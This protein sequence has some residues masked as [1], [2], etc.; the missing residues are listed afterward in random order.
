M[1]EF[2]ID[3]KIN[4]SKEKVWKAVTDFENYPRWNSV[5]IME[6]NNDLTLGEKFH[7][8]IISVKG[9]K[10]KFKAV[11]INKVENHSFSA[12]R[13]MRIGKWFFQAI[14][15]FI[16]KEI[17]DNNVIFSQEWELKGLVAS[18][19]RKKIHAELAVFT[20]MNEELK[21]LIEN[22]E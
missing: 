14:H 16:T 19:M 5:L 13:T 9:I 22:N 18:L 15:H 1:N 2:K 12:K 11:A 8:T 7:V 10:M 6:N 21:T 17:D 20:K 4:A 3:I